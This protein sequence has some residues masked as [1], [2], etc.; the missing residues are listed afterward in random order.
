PFQGHDL[1]QEK[2]TAEERQERV[3]VL[4]RPRHAPYSHVLW[5]VPTTALRWV[6]CVMQYRAQALAVLVACSCFCSTNSPSIRIW[7][8]SAT[9]HLP[10]IIM[11]NV[12]PKSFRLI[13]PSA[14]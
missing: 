14:L 6:W 3:A 2:V 1:D 7:T 12:M 8:S 4:Q 9:I 13:L 11:L 10:S 5:C